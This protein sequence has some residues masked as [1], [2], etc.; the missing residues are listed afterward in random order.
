[1]WAHSQ[2]THCIL[3]QRESPPCIAKF[4]RGLEVDILIAIWELVTGVVAVVAVVL[5]LTILNWDRCSQAQTLQKGRPFCSMNLMTYRYV[6]RVNTQQKHSITLDDTLW[7]F[8][9]V[10]SLG[11]LKPEKIIYNGFADTVTF[12]DG[13][14]IQG[15]VTMEGIPWRVTL[16][17]Q[18]CTRK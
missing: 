10:E 4:D 11:I 7:S 1:M 3:C 6:L 16:N 8:W 2:P 18:N 15:I 14:Y 17:E 13:R 9:D 12:Q 5:Q